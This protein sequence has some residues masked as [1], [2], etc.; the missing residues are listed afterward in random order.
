[1]TA[2]L[3]TITSTATTRGAAIRLATAAAM[4]AMAISSATGTAAAA[5]AGYG[6]VSLD[7]VLLNASQTARIVGDSGLAFD[8]SGTRLRDD[9]MSV[10]PASCLSTYAPAEAAA[11]DTD[12]VQGVAVSRFRN[13]NNT[14]VVTEAVV[15]MPTKQDALAQLTSTADIWKACANRTI[16]DTTS[17]GERRQW[18]NSAPAVNNDHTIVSMTQSAGG[19]AMTCERAMAAYTNIVIDVMSCGQG[20][21]DGQGVA[22]ATAIATEASSQSN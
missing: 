12:Q 18:T 9:T 17:S 6:S 8:A 16:S 7:S 15:A 13:S 21:T 19:G 22:V 4:A 10:S 11:Y 2:T 1:M 20:A 5:P 3:K 14:T